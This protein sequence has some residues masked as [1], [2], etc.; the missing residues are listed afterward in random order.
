M[1]RTIL[2]SSILLLSA[3]WA[4]AQY[5]SDSD[6]Q[7]QTPSNKTTIEGCLEGAIGTTR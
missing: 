1:R 4:V 6:N 7:N 5:N 3:V 2:L